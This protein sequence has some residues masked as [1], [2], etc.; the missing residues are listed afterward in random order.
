MRPSNPWRRGSD[1]Y[2]TI[3]MITG[4]AA[5]I[6]AGV[7]TG[8]ALAFA[9]RRVEEVEGDVEVLDRRVSQLENG[10]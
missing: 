9:G 6:G 1:P 4:L 10:S 5:L 3:A 7:A 8:A 2:Q